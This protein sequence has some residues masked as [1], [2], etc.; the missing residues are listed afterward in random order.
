MILLKISIL[1]TWL[2]YVL[3]IYWQLKGWWS[4][5]TLI[6]L[7]GGGWFWFKVVVWPPRIGA[8]EKFYPSTFWGGGG[9]ETNGKRRGLA[10]H[11]GKE[12]QQA[13]KTAIK[14][15]IIDRRIEKVGLTTFKS[16]KSR[17]KS[18]LFRFSTKKTFPLNKSEMLLKNVLCLVPKAL[19]NQNLNLFSRLFL[20][21]T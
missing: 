17:Q 4:K 19:R 20:I 11:T 15:Y 10:R 16:F 3:D 8:E 9:R 7:N 2:Y 18:K 5:H 13:S 6:G 14:L 12:V 1:K 21:L